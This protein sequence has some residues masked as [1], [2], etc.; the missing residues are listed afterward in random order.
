MVARIGSQWI[1]GAR[2]CVLSVMRHGLLLRGN[3]NRKNNIWCMEIPTRFRIFLCVSLKSVSGVERLQ[4][5]SYDPVFRTEKIGYR[6]IPWIQTLFIKEYLLMTNL[7]HFCQCIYFTP[8]YVSSKK[9]SSS[10]ESNCVNTSGL[11]HSSRWLVLCPVEHTRQSPTR[12]YYTRWCM[13]QFDPP[14]DEHLL[15]ETCRGVK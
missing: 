7:T 9:C 2:T 14:D 3:V 5:K 1:S 11:I 8:L 4:A 12:V 6:C 15:P 13:T 10:G